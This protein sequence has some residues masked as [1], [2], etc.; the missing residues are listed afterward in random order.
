MITNRVAFHCRMQV[1][2]ILLLETQSEQRRSKPCC[3]CFYDSGEAQ[4]RRQGGC[5]PKSQKVPPDGIVKD[6][7][8]YKTNVVVV[9]LTI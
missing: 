3:T 9:G 8:G 4:A 2:R 7:K 1:F 6:L 5:A